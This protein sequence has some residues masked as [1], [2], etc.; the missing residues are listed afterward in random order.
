MDEH[1]ST[2]PGVK[3]IALEADH[4]GMNKFRAETEHN[5]ELVRGQI[6]DMVDRIEE[7]Q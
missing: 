5:Y 1:S 7:G 6:K 4:I 3:R 2:N